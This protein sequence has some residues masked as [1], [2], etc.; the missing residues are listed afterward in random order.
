MKILYAFILFCCSLN[1][2]A[3]Q[4]NLNFNA[5]K[6]MTCAAYAEKSPVVDGIISANEYFGG[7]EQFGVL[8]AG[9]DMLSSRQAK[10]YAALDDKY[11]YL[12]CQSELP[13]PES[14]VELMKK[15]KKRDGNT[16]LDDSIEFLIY[17]PGAGALYHLIINPANVAFDLQYPEVNGG[18]GPTTRKDWDP[19]FFAK[20]SFSGKYWTLELKIPLK[21][22][23][24]KPSQKRAEWRFQFARGWK[25]PV[26]QCAVNR[27]TVYANLEQMN[28]VI[29]EKNSPAV[30]FTGMGNYTEGENDISFTIDNPGTKPVKIQYKVTVLSEASPRNISNIIS[31]PPKTSKK[32]AL[33]YTEK[34]KLTN[35]MT[36]IFT[37]VETGK[38]L[39]QRCLAW[40][41]PAGKRWIA[42]DIKNGAQLEIGIYP[43]YKLIRARLGNHGVPF[44]T[45]NV[46]SIIMR[47]TDD[48]GFPVSKNFTPVK[49]GN[50][51][52]YSEMPL[53]QLK[54]GNYYVEAR[55]KKEDG[56]EEFFKTKFFFNSYEWEHNNIGC[57][58][59][60]LPPYKP[61]VYSGNT[62][63]TL[64]T[65]YTLANGFF[66]DIKTGKAEK[67]L[68]AP[69]TMTVNGKTLTGSRIKWTE[70]AA[71]QG[72]AIQSLN[73]SGLDVTVS[74]TV[75]FDNFVKTVVSIKPQKEFKF[76]S[77]T[78][79]IPLNSDFAK[80]I[81][82]T[83]NVMRHNVVASL[84]G[85]Q[86]EIWNSMQGRHA[87]AIA[88]KFR[89][90]IWIGNM[91][92]GLAFFAENDK[93][94]SRDPQKPMAQLIRK[95]NE[96]RLR[97]NFVDK[98]TVRKEPFT[99]TFGF[100]ATP[101]RGRTNSS[102]Q[103]T[104]RSNLPNSVRM[105]LLAG[106]G[107]W[108]CDDFDFFPKNK[109][110][111]Y[112]NTL[113]KLKGTPPDS[114]KREEIINKFMHNFAAY[115]K[116]RQKFYINH[117]D[118]GITYA[119]M[120][121]LLIPYMNPRASHLR[122]E[123][124][125]VFMDEWFCSDFR[126]NNEDAYNNSPTRSYQ[127]FLLFHCKKLLNEGL[128]G[129]YYDNIRDWHNP[130]TVTG[131]AY[132]T[133]SGKI[134]PYF[135]IFDM[136]TLL[137]RAA[138]LIHKEGKNI[139]DGRPLFVVHMTDTNIVPF[140][141]L[142]SITIDWEDKFGAMDY[143]DRFSEDYIKICTLGL[144]SGAIP[145]ILVQLSGNNREHVT[146]TFLAVTLA[147]DLPM[148]LNGGNPTATLQKIWRIL[149]EFG[150]GT[151]DV[152]TFP[153]FN[154]SGRLS[155]NSNNIRMTEY[156][157]KNGM[158]AVAVSSFG[159]SGKTLLNPGF[160]VKEAI[161]FETGKT[162]PLKNNSAEFDLKKN[163]FRLILFK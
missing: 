144:Q 52:Y 36:V 13:D 87:G 44:N 50:D 39:L 93:N 22:L 139:F 64:M 96:T 27:V 108:S 7:Y 88:N 54:K 21:E 12:A 117:L 126:A 20:S 63:Q 135:D 157:K 45:R 78:L 99:L 68:A 23:N 159:H 5:R 138:V 70:K 150:Y 1:L 67:L 3:Q 137:K 97:I 37:E 112:I 158:T 104:E 161:D 49:N 114:K 163:E 60:V 66:S 2:I 141:S 106:G 48:K 59:I 80:H 6:T 47:V 160:P 53:P 43:Y 75:E 122:W 26:Q 132:V 127:D 153:C 35:E 129:L 152:E 146:R 33:Q 130:N 11:L 72:T 65:R 90:Y 95:D 128:D 148:V 102:R 8:P 76:N 55:L 29:F 113:S 28:P 31:I 154:P 142:G 84:S 24:T 77:M 10:F 19:D 62:I 61:L 14:G 98:P 82:S 16:P 110:Y 118:R 103:L 15:Y 140:T 41:L 115:P 32:V 30:R 121:E 134:Q 149:K 100:Q 9:S 120:S 131:P 125:N 73:I 71:D 81:H 25:N 17:P 111:S 151:D 85:K 109:D 101:T 58:R 136:R 51:G 89:P 91:A 116:D 143:Q 155:V 79:E 57:D 124:Y 40:Q 42:P 123:E 18:I 107:C 92:E 74:N 56:K 105:S 86:G 156:R 145:E 133:D 4:G 162:I 147:Y 83:C 69:I 34:A 38:V 119:Q 94:Y 46:K